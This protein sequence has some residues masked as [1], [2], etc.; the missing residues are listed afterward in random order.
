MM[1]LPADAP[2]FVPRSHLL[3]LGG[4]AAVF[5][6]SAVAPHDYFTWMLEV[7][8]GVIGVGVL[9]AIYRRFR[10]TTLVYVLVALHAAILF[11]GG[12]YTYAQVPLFNWIRDSFHLSR[13]HFDR[14]GHFAQGFVPAMIA[15]EVLLRCSPL[16]RGKWLFAIVVSIC[17]AISAVYE[18]FEW[19]TAVVSGSSADAFLGTQGDPFDT[20]KDMFLCLIGAI[21]SLLLLSRWQDRQLQQV[22]RPNAP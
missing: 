9:I 3:L 8:P 2:R 12:H 22:E 7:F 1:R 21:A 19:G 6:W 15:R 20:Q 14:V 4:L 17:M 10:F 5:A 11:T 13:N 16:R 18:L